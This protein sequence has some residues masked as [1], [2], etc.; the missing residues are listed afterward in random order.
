MWQKYID[1]ALEMGACDVRFLDP[2]QVVTAPW[3]RHKC[4]FGCG[5]YGKNRCCPPF[6][7]DWKTT[8]EILDGFSKGLLVRNTGWNSTEIARDLARMLFLDGYYKAIGFGSGGCRLC[9]ECDLENC[10]H[11]EKIIPSMEACGIDVFATARAQ[12][13]PIEVLTEKGQAH[14][15]YCLVLIE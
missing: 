3:V 6:A 13:F 10:R 11:P 12:G 15:T 5:Q 9:K 1:R 4:Q 2:R 7:P 8:R 14:N